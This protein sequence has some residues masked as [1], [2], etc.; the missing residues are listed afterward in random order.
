[1]PHCLTPGTVQSVTLDSF[2]GINWE[3]SREKE[4]HKKDSIINRSK[5]V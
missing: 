2:D 5:D 4:S 3:A 1:M